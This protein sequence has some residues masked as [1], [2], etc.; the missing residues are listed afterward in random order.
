[1]LVELQVFDRNARLFARVIPREPTF[2]KRLF[3][4]AGHEFDRLDRLLGIER[5]PGS[6]QAVVSNEKTILKEKTSSP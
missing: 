2:V 6:A 3:I 4:G 1:L 5:S